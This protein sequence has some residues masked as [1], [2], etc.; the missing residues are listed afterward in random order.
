MDENIGKDK[1][2]PS[3]IVIQVTWLLFQISMSAHSTQMVVI[4]FVLTQMD[5]II[6]A[7]GVGTHWIQINI[8]VKVHSLL[9]NEDF[10][11][12]YFISDINECT[13]NS[14]GCDQI[15]F[16]TIG[17]YLCT[18]RN[19]YALAANRRTCEGIMSTSACTWSHHIFVHCTLISQILMNV[20]S[21]L[22]V[23]LTVALTPLDPIAAVV[24][25]GT[26]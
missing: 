7:V 9:S 13:I 11:S 23:V 6:V 1:S 20:P 26:D 18:C 17:S 24:G 12:I 19:G 15:C 25:M 3:G 22:M 14:H 8:P 2:Q 21:T 5:P 10:Y 16:N 4:T